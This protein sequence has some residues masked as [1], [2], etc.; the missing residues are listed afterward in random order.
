MPSIWRQRCL[1]VSV[2]IFPVFNA[3]YETAVSAMAAKDFV[4]EKY[5]DAAT[6]LAILGIVTVFSYAQSIKFSGQ[7]T[8]DGVKETIGII[9]ERKL[10]DD[11][12]TISRRQEVTAITL[13]T[14]VLI[15]ATAAD[16][17]GGDYFVSQT[18]EDYGFDKKIDPKLWDDFAIL[19][20]VIAGMTTVFTEGIGFYKILRGKF[21]GEEVIYANTASRY[22]CYLLGYPISMLGAAENLM[23]AYASIKDKLSPTTTLQKYGVMIACA[24][25]LPSDFYFSGKEC[26]DAI[27]AL[28][29]KLSEGLPKASEAAAFTLSSGVAV[30]VVLPQPFL[31]K[32]LMNDPA[33]S[34]PF[35][36]PEIVTQ[37]L[38][39]GVALRDG[40][41]Q[42]RTLYPLFHAVTRAIDKNI[43][44]CLT[45]AKNYMNP[46]V[47][48]LT[49]AFLSPAERVEAENAPSRHIT[50]DIPTQTT[51]AIYSQSHPNVLFKPVSPT[52]TTAPQTPLSSTRM[53]SPS[54]SP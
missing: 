17:F 42:T 5:T 43:R 33:T 8:V 31:T 20:G 22:I 14:V 16:F 49:E 4:D 30:L 26:R 23:E 32:D 10:P 27:D 39:Y 29:G 11:W 12:P 21:A 15:S 52:T 48:D 7:K 53:S 19:T 18:P 45:H 41:V 38:S 28:V 44:A 36:S 46:T 6:K 54:F 13:A 50:I 9:G 1:D 24:P 40:I 51:E 34:L 47:P 2:W 3:F 25:K 35:T 37:S